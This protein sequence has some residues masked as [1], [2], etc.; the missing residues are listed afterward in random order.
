MTKEQAIELA[1]SRFWEAMSFR[2]RAEFQLHE[3]LLCMPFGVF[4]EAV[5]KALGRPVWTHEFG[6][7][8]NLKA[9]LMGD[10]PAPTMREIVDM[11]PAEKR[12]IVAVG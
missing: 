2:E 11:I 7:M 5:E 12:V 1:E 9:E 3:P 8:G 10:R 6:S 4:H